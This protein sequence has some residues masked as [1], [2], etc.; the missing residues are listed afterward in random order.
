MLP[1]DFSKEAFL[2]K[3]R[4]TFHSNCNVKIEKA[5]CQD[6]P[7]KRIK[8]SA[9][10][11]ER[12]KHIALLTSANFAHKKIA[13]K[14]YKDHGVR[15]SF[16]FRLPRFVSCLAYLM[17]PGK[18]ASTDLDL[19]PARYPSGLDL[20]KELKGHKNNTHFM[21]WARILVTGGL[22]IGYTSLCC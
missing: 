2:Q 5:T 10:K 19:A 6:E 13:D 7:H 22:T 9:D 16:S 17:V 20:D 3:L 4:R 1:E 8:P 14:F 21:L 15:I 12:H 18:K 11:R